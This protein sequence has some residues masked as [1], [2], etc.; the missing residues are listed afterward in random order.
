MEAVQN[1]IGAAS[2]GVSCRA[3][4][5]SK[6]LLTRARLCCEDRIALQYP[7]LTSEFLGQLK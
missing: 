6:W 5:Y 3:C 2:L 1:K 4:R 7:A